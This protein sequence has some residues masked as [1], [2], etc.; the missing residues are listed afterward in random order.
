M[1]RGK[2]SARRDTKNRTRRYSREA[3]ATSPDSATF[4]TAHCWRKHSVS[5]SREKVV[6][7]PKVLQ[8]TSPAHEPARE[9]RTL[10]SSSESRVD[11]VAPAAFGHQVPQSAPSPEISSATIN[12]RL[13]ELHALAHDP[14]S[15]SAVVL[16]IQEAS[17]QGVDRTVHAPSQSPTWT[18]GAEWHNSWAAHCQFGQRS[19]RGRPDGLRGRP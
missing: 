5:Q 4:H 14:P 15:R 18:F 3:P 7:P 11:Q 12:L 8:M 16:P 13:L 1:S 17:R 19:S 2:H 9:C 6:V 10:S